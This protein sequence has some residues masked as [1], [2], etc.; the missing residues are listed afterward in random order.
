MVFNRMYNRKRG[1]FGG[2][3]YPKRRNYGFKRVPRPV[4]AQRIPS[5]IVK[6][7]AF[8]TVSTNVVSGL[9]TATIKMS[10]L[11]QSDTFRKYASLTERFAVH[12]M[13][14]KFI[15]KSSSAHMALS[16][17]SKD[18]EEVISDI[19]TYLRSPSIFN[20][21]IVKD[22]ECK[23]FVSAKDLP[24][25]QEKI[26]TGQASQFLG[27]PHYLSSIKLLVPNASGTD[28]ISVY[29][30]WSVSFDGSQDLNSTQ[31][32]ALTGN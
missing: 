14:V 15:C 2:A 28:S 8:N 16:M 7:H 17:I 19:S 31:F 1:S 4:P 25:L 20:H 10:D 27:Q 32:S 21:N 12:S 13:S 26:A 24:Q 9:L 18:D 30:T 23:R 11:L 3:P 6:C 5:Q 29:V 22:Q